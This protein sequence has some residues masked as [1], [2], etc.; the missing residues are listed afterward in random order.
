[1]LKFLFLHFSFLQLFP[2]RTEVLCDSELSNT[3]NILP[4]GIFEDKTEQVWFDNAISP[5]SWGGQCQSVTQLN[6]FPFRHPFR[7]ILIQILCKQTS[8]LLDKN[9]A[10]F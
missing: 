10:S 1:M 4:Y 2:F 3:I 9:R 6:S 7:Q 5:L 8:V